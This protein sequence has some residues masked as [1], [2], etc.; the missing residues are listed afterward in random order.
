MKKP[1]T[2]AQIKALYNALAL[3][4]LECK[5]EFEVYPKVFILATVSF[6]RPYDF[7]YEVTAHAWDYEMIVRGDIKLE[8]LLE[9]LNF[10]EYIYDNF[11]EEIEKVES[12]H[13]KPYIGKFNAL[14]PAWE[15]YNKPF[16]I[17]DDSND[18][19]PF[20]EFE[21]TFNA[22]TLNPPKM[23]KIELTDDYDAQVTSTKSYVSVGCQR[24]PIQAVR[25]IVTTY[26]KLN[27]N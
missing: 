5:Y 20:V 7:S 10:N 21:K 12:K 18:L 9:S 23:V 24:V 15:E 14:I 11:S 6:D 3:I 13:L 26:D 4:P 2:K 19:I 17:W 8:R 22:S 25:D 27:P 1:K 16:N